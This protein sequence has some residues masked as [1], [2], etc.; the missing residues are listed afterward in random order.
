MS[1]RSE[2]DEDTVKVHVTPLGG[3][4]VNERE[5]LRSKAARDMM[6][7]MDRVLQG[8]GC[9]HQDLGDSAPGRQGPSRER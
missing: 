7:K 4:Y 6:K 1:K 3:L 2:P 5:L 8:D 9:G